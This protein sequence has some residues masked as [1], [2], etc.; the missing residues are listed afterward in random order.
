M[1][2]ETFDV[3]RSVYTRLPNFV[4]DLL[5]KGDCIE[6]WLM[7]QQERLAV[8]RLLEKLRPEC[9][10]EVG[11]LH[12][13][14]LSVIAKYARKVFSLDIDQ[15][16]VNKLKDRPQFSNV[17]FVVGDC[18][19][20]LPALLQELQ[21]K[22]PAI[23]FALIDASHTEADVRRDINNFIKYVPAKPLYIVMHDSFMPGCRRGMLSADWESSPYVHSVH[24]DFIPGVFNPDDSMS[25]GL[26]LALMLPTKRTHK[27]EVLQDCAKLF[28][29]MRQHSKHRESIFRPIRR[30]LGKVKR[31]LLNR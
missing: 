11:T 25:C 6:D 5:F 15:E 26:A 3:S 30:E 27:L 12:G 24:I 9:A 18:R 17:E 4:N 8:F 13:G 16:N 28:E 31:K 22:G 14:C 19:E 21:R 20:T 29:V 23:E 2:A 10:V 1:T 7:T